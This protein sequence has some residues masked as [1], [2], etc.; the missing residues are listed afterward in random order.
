M[1]LAERGN[2]NAQS[3]AGY[4]LMN[5]LGV[6]K[7]EANVVCHLRTAA[8]KGVASAMNNNAICLLQGSGCP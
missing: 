5:G 2:P 1:N 6:Q 4:L 3:I 8:S 7:N